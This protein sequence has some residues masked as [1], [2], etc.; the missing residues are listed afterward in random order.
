MARAPHVARRTPVP[1]R[2]YLHSRFPFDSPDTPA[3]MERLSR[4]YASF[5]SAGVSSA[6]STRGALLRTVELVK[7]APPNGETGETGETGKGMLVEVC[8]GMKL[9]AFRCLRAVNL[10][11]IGRGSVKLPCAVGILFHRVTSRFDDPLRRIC[12]RTAGN[13]SFLRKMWVW[14][15]KMSDR[16]K[17]SGS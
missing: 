6:R 17:S 2:G 5:D 8:R 15:E 14:R 4:F 13:T 7:T 11:I 12:S 16:T 9:R 3:G 10:R 1:S